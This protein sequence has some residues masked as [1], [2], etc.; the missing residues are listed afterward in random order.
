MY[1]NLINNSIK[2]LFYNDKTYVLSFSFSLHKIELNHIL[3]K[4]CLL[5]FSKYV[6]T[7]EMTL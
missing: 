1:V 3:N 2:L 7:S 4:D 6:L 5:Y